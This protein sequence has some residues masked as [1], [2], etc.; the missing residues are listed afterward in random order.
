MPRFRTASRCPQR[1]DHQVM[2][3]RRCGHP[4]LAGDAIWSP[5]LRSAPTLLQLGVLTKTLHT[6]TL[7]RTV[8]KKLRV[9]TRWVSG[10]MAFVSFKRC[11]HRHRVVEAG[12]RV[13]AYIQS[14]IITKFTPV[15]L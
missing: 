9:R 2:F 5:T 6:Y 10:A 7:S 11:R 4:E 14:T 12:P 3:V 8:Q 1:L 15:Y 13:Q